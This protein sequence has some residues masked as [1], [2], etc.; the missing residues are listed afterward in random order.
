MTEPAAN[1]D[2]DG[3]I[4]VN[5]FVEDDEGQDA[6]VVL[7]WSVDSEAFPD[8]SHLSDRAVRERTLADPSAR[9]PL[10]ILTP[11]P[12]TL[13]QARC[14]SFG[15]A[16]DKVLLMD[17][18][19][20]REFTDRA[21]RGAIFELL[22]D[23]GAVEQSAV[24]ASAHPE[25]RGLDLE[26]A[27]RPPPRPGQRAR[28]REDPLTFVLDLTTSGEGRYLLPWDAPVDLGTSDV[29]TRFFIK[30]TPFGG[31]IQGSS[32]VTDFGKRV[33]TDRLVFSDRRDL[34][35]GDELRGLTV[36]DF[37]GDGRLDLAAV[38]AG[39]PGKLLVFTAAENG[40][41]SG[42][43][44]L[45]TGLDPLFVTTADLDDDGHLDLIVADQA[46][47]LD[48]DD[49][50]SLYFGVGDGTFAEPPKALRTGLRPSGAAVADFNGDG[51]LDLVAAN[52][53]D[54]AT[55][56]LSVFLGAGAREF[57]EA[58]RIDTEARAV[59]VTAADLDDDGL[60]D[61]VAAVNSLG[62][63]RS[64]LAIFLARL[65][66]GE[67]VFERPD[68]PV[69]VTGFCPVAVVTVDLNG[70]ALL[71]LVSADKTSDQLSIFFGRGNGAFD[72]SPRPLIV[73]GPT[74]LT[75][76]DLNGE[77]HADLVASVPGEGRLDLFLGTGDGSFVRPDPPTLETLHAASSI[78]IADLTGDGRLD[79]VSAGIGPSR[80]AFFYGIE[81]QFSRPAPL[82]LNPGRDPRAVVTVDV[83]GDGRLDL[84]SASTADNHLALFLSTVDGT[85]GSGKPRHLMT[86]WK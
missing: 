80:L 23:T 38:D 5:F 53:F 69:L 32:F 56:G 14:R 72:S 68:P 46:V 85:F 39:D 25:L 24:V 59:A 1:P 34:D 78:Q 51:H 44:P 31:E 13:I 86:G 10:A 21:L 42:P 43:L 8:I 52:S 67:L 83:N 27:L 22:S 20:Q 12:R 37:N 18:A 62:C 57:S 41:Y 35:A 19:P 75:A 65:T 77:G 55:Q 48:M 3:S 11:R 73:A 79:V 4:V 64:E 17:V 26:E 61:L 70:D 71:D 6:D 76:A 63:G 60:P 81:A 54:E 74:A 47:E 45:E 66:D 29:T 16:D 9:A 49:T 30:A 2:V 28:V 15:E 84:V 7:Q 33:V 36:G 58:M 50:L 40:I 82:T